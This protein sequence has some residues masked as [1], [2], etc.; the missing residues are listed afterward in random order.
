MTRL[1][2]GGTGFIGRNLAVKLSKMGFH[3]R[4][5]VRDMSRAV[6]MGECPG[7]EPFLGDIQYKNSIIP[8]ISNINVVFHLAGLT[9][10]RNKDEYIRINAEGTGILC[11][12]IAMQGKGIRKILHVSSLAGAGP[13]TSRYPARE[14]GEVS[15]VTH[16]GKANYW[17]SNCFVKNA[18][19]FPGP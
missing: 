9:K 4:C 13:H 5:L 18:K 3:V 11:D 2:T 6:W 15:P 10:A 7:L 1:L 19:I 14:N 17:V 12:A 16:Y 8:H